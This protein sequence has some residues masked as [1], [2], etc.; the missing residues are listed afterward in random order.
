MKLNWDLE[1][2][3]QG[4]ARARWEGKF[5]ASWDSQEG[6][7][8]FWEVW[9]V[10]GAQERP[11]VGVRLG[12]PWG[13]GR[14]GGLDVGMTSLRERVH[15]GE[16]QGTSAVTMLRGWGEEQEANLRQRNKSP[17]QERAPGKFTKRAASP[18]ACGSVLRSC[19]GP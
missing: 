5:R 14:A 4:E 9:D 10:I 12:V 1:V 19:C 6:R 3:E 8:D 18:W 11:G 17:K 15:G 7:R 13:L 2:K 16:N